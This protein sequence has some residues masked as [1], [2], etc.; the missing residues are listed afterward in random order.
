MIT[1]GQVRSALKDYVHLQRFLEVWFPAGAAV[2]NVTRGS[3]A[4]R[5]VERFVLARADIQ[6]VMDAL[7]FSVAQLGPLDR[8]IVTTHYFQRVGSAETAGR[9]GI[10]RRAMFTRLDVI[11]AEI[12]SRLNVID[13][14]LWEAFGRFAQVV[15]EE[16]D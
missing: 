4:G 11:A 16:N 7:A 1:P 9:L 8:Q 13:G 12:S 10:S 5:P 3:G 2:A 6:A 15:L 14:R